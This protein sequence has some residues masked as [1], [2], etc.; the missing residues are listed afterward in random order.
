[1]DTATEVPTVWSQLAETLYLRDSPTAEVRLSERASFSFGRIQSTV[2]LPEITRPVVGER[3]H[4]VVLQLKP[5]PFI[6]QFFGKKKVSSGSYPIGGVSAIDLTRGTS[7]SA[8]ESLRR[9]GALYH[10]SCSG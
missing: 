4:I 6:E 9:T 3:G 2:G 10:S 5:I 7:R 1:M 8:S